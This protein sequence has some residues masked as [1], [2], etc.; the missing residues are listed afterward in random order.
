M[1][2]HPATARPAPGESRIELCRVGA[3]LRVRVSV[4][5]RVR[6]RVRVS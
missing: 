2:C 4:R 5:V 1:P 3:R 6:V